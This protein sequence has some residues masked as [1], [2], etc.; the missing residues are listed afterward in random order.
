M[1]LDLWRLVP[2]Y[3]IQCY[4]TSLAWDAE[5]NRCLDAGPLIFEDDKR[6]MIGGKRI[7]I[8][9]WPYAYGAHV[10]PIKEH[11]RLPTVKTRRRLRRE[12]ARA[13]AFLDA[14]KA[15]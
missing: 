11:L 3:Q 8:A 2:G 13:R 15:L 6:A 12:V 7:W 10:Q 1:I 9:D 5:L 4:P 14:A